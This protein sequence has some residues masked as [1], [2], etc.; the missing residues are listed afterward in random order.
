[1]PEMQF[2]GVFI[3]ECA[4]AAARV[5]R[6]DLS[7]AAFVGP[8]R[9]GPARGVPELLT[10]LQ[11]FENLYGDDQPLSWEQGLVVPNYLWHAARCF[12][13]E[14]G[15]RLYVSRVFRALAGAPAGEP[16]AP[17]GLPPHADG[18]ARISVGVARQ[19]F[20]AVAR[21]P[22]AAGNLQLRMGLLLGPDLLDHPGGGAPAALRPGALQAGDVVW[23]ETAATRQALAARGPAPLGHARALGDLPL[24]QVQRDAAGAC[25]FAGVGAGALTSADLGLNAAA[26]NRLCVVSL[27]VETLGEDGRGLGRWSGCSLDPLRFDGPFVR[28]GRGPEAMPGAQVVLLNDSLS[29]GLELLAALLASDGGQGLV[30]AAAELAEAGQDEML[31]LRRRLERGVTVSARLRGGNDGLLPLPSDYAGAAPARGAVPDAGAGLQALV[32]LEDVAI[33]AAPG[34]SAR[35]CRPP[36][37]AREIAVLLLASAASQRMALLDPPDG[38]SVSGLLGWRAGLDDSRAALYHPWVSVLDPRTARPLNL[39]PSGFVAGVY[40]RMER[41]RGVW[42]A[43]A[44]EALRLASGLESA[45]GVAQQELLNPEGINLLRFMAGRGFL[46]W[47]ARTLSR[48]PAWIYVSARRYIDSLER[49]LR[50]GLRWV[51]FEPQGEPM[52]SEVRRQVQDYLLS[53]WRAGALQGQKAEQAFFLRCDRSSMSQRD[54]DAGRVVV[55]LGV[56]LLQPAEFLTLR[57]SLQTLQTAPGG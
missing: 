13:A 23:M 48:D 6:A 7:T 43:P 30:L 3:E 9:W 39:P 46:V 41:E 15:Q 14:G 49:S 32:S 19:Q 29:T 53:E 38:A 8:C 47:G 25:V 52:W 12:F 22:G 17:A 26:G 40:A 45:L 11:D 4:P 27:T 34:A 56:A 35:S 1:M 5:Q 21:H 50:A 16:S 55:M 36:Q 37:Q 2:P 51:A 24:F 54:I 31:A 20:Q 18:H 44:G 28:L 10:S 57:L 33:L 42:K